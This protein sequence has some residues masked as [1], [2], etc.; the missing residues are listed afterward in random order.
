MNHL[1]KNFFAAS[2][3]MTL[4]GAAQA[5]VIADLGADYIDSSTLPANYSYLQS[6]NANG[7]TETALLPNQVLGNG[8]NTGWG[9]GPGAT[10]GFNLAGVLGAI[11]G[12]SEFEIF[13]DGQVNGGVVGTDLLLHPTN[14]GE[15]ATV[16][17]RRTITAADLINGTD[18][19]ITGSFRNLVS[20]YSVVVGIFQNDSLLFTDSP[21]ADGPGSSSSF[22]V[23]TTLAVGDK[24]DFIVGSNGGFQGDETA[25]NA[26][27]D[28]VP[29]PSS[30]ALLGLG[31]LCMLRRRRA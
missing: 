10:G 16:I 6:T 27:I 26:T 11:N 19:T 2:A 28:V 3:A 1:T 22:N 5:V 17:I 8:G 24:I 25:L 4:C 14:G 7:G 23:S 21:P 30:M 12:G 15:G 18:A 9:G 29:E 13:G 31:G 20:S